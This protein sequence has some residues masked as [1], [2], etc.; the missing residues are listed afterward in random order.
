MSTVPEPGARG[1]SGWVVWIA[2]AGLLLV[3]LGT[4]HIVQGVGALLTDQRF[5]LRDTEPFLDLSTTTSGW[6]HVIVGGVV[7]VAG[8]LVF[9]GWTWAR[10]VGA[11]V[12]VLSALSAVSF[13]AEHPIW[14]LAVIAL[15]VTVVLALVLHGDEIKA[16]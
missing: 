6:L 13:L 7:A 10:V 9:G 14:A 16:G 8:F 1:T 15:D 4:F 11:T 12:A 3:L 5:L 2:L